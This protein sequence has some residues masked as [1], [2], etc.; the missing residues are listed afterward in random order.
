MPSETARWPGYSYALPVGRW[1]GARRDGKR[2]R[3]CLAVLPGEG[4]CGGHPLHKG[5]HRAGDSDGCTHFLT[6]DQVPHAE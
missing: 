4:R 5:P 2:E 3:R 1:L 6:P